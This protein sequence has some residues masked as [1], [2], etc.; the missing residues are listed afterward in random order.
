MT[1]PTTNPSQRYEIT[2]EQVQII[3]HLFHIPD[4][5]MDD[6]D[7]M[8]QD[9]ILVAI[10]SR[11]LPA[12]PTNP[13]DDQGCTDPDNCDEICQHQRI[14]SQVQMDEKVAQA[15]ADALDKAIEWL[16]AMADIA[17]D[18]ANRQ[19]NWIEASGYSLF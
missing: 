13:C 17:N 7:Y 11:P 2:E 10:R 3:Y 19:E 9:E 15:R 6:A 8:M 12:A 18:D 4:H 14:Y 16:Q 5:A 1:A